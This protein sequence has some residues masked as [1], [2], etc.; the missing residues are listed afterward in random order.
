MEVS[1]IVQTKGGGAGDV[2]REV[3]SL[4][5]ALERGATDAV[6][7]TGLRRLVG[8]GVF[9]WLERRGAPATVQELRIVHEWVLGGVAAHVEEL[10]A[11]QRENARI[12]ERLQFILPNARIMVGEIDRELRFR[13]LYDPRQFPEGAEMIGRSV[14]ELGDPVFAERIA[15]IL[16]RVIR[17]GV[18]ERV[19]L[20]PPQDGPPEHVLTSFEPTRDATGEVSG[21]LFAGTEITELK[22]AQLAL[23]QSVAF[24]E[25]MLAVLAHDLRNPLSSVLALARLYVRNEEVPP[26]VQRALSRIDQ[27]S[28]R[29]VEL[30]SMILDFSA[31][32]FGE[33]LPV[34]RVDSDLLDIARAAVDEL[35]SAAP[36]RHIVLNAD[37]ETRGTWDPARMAQV[38]SNLVG[39]ALTHGAAHEPVVVEIEGR[40]GRVLLRVTNRGP[41]IAPDV[42]PLLFEPFRRGGDPGA[43]PRGLGLGLYIVQQIVKAHAGAIRVESTIERGTIFSVDM[44]SAQ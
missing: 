29:M 44:P 40:E 23:A 42:M 1:A 8:D 38:V 41:T 43:R 34:A 30:I 20:S 24:R 31:S 35:R 33:A 32:R 19:E 26:K 7:A 15:Q 39:N 10:E 11:S 16:R 4:I 22:Q 27:A 21:V 14:G 25:Q 18:G 28:Q 12:A 36:E 6:G 17:T 2:A 37:G 3:D 5:S 13:W 9:D